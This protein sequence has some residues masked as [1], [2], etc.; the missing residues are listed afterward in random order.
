MSALPPKADMCSA[1][2]YVRFVPKADINALHSS[3][4]EASVLACGGQSWAWKTAPERKFMVTVE[5]KPDGDGS[6][7]TLTH[8]Q[9]FDDEAR[10]RHQHGWN[11]AMDKLEKYLAA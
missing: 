1:T 5:I 11:G 2:R 7:M 4:E 10:D 3:Q 9:F 6:V 8:E